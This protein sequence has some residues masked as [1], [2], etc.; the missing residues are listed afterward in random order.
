[1]KTTKVGRHAVVEG[2][3][4]GKVSAWAGFD[5]WGADSKDMGPSIA[6][7]RSQQWQSWSLS[8][9]GIYGNRTQ[10]ER[11][12]PTVGSLMPN[13]GALM[14]TSC[15]GPRSFM[16]RSTSKGQQCLS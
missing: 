11:F 16:H 10:F 2:T 7:E 12:D 13:D 5:H 9:N 8:S 1:M 15:A 3:T 6:L 4:A 14:C